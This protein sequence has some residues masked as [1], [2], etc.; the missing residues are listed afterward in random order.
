MSRRIRLNRRPLL[1]AVVTAALACPFLA[2]AAGEPVA[3]PSESAPAFEDARTGEPI[4]V[5]SSFTGTYLAGR[6]AQMIRDAE[7]ASRFFSS[8][9]KSEPDDISL[10]GRT[11]QV[12]LADG[13][14]K[15]ALPL[16]DRVAA[17]TED[18][19]FADLTLAVEDARQG[20]FAAAETRIEKI[21]DNGF[22]EILKPLAIAWALAG[23][24]KTDD[25]L[26]RLEPLV[27]KQGF[28][29]F[30]HIHGAFI[31]DLAGRTK[32]AQ[33]A[34]EK[35]AA[36]Q[37]DMTFRFVSLYGGFLERTGKAAQ[38]KTLYQ[39]FIAKTPGAPALAETLMRPDRRAARELASAQDGLADALFDLASAFGRGRSN[40]PG[41]LLGILSLHLRPAFTS[42]Q[43]LVG[44]LLETQGR[45]KRANEIY[46]E[47]PQSDPFWSTVQLRIASN[48]DEMKNLDEAVAHLRRL[49]EARPRD[50]DP[51]VELGRTMHRHERFPE[52]V[53]ALDQAFQRLEG[54]TSKDWR[55]YYSRGMALERAGQW[56]RAEQD[57]LKALELEPEQ[58]FVLNYL[59]YSWVDQGMNIERARGMIEK[60]VSLRP[61]DGFIV[62]SL[63]WVHYR[64]GDFASAVRELE[65]AVELR[66]HDA[67]INDH[68]GDAYWKV[69]RREEARF[70]WRRALSFNP[71]EKEREKIERKLKN[72]LPDS[73]AKNDG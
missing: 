46:A 63:G 30:A 13:R 49:A 22:T 15:E 62:D 35:A 50:P 66:P 26:K 17:Q 53:A 51:L 43:V 5:G 1:G 48:L 18:A 55:L 24:N 71:E 34:F 37:K 29:I 14:V 68:L 70:Q 41:L 61:T 54:G 33:A 3:Q 56:P 73:T 67:V 2:E 6:H 19:L 52:A 59:G 12:L 4:Q 28:E 36:A 32:A 69:G 9:L 16:A 31:N 42:A 58:P 8:A 39:D 38:A 7:A 20:R 11:F 40:D 57:F 21:R 23:Q 64:S 25:A 60:A 45:L 27:G 44:E 65:R 47:V 72:G 10:L